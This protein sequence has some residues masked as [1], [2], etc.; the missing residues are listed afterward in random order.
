MKTN[1]YLA[2]TNVLVDED[3]PKPTS[4]SRWLGIDRT[5]LFLIGVFLGAAVERWRG[6]S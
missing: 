1:D 6:R 3:P 2:G 5:W 4:I